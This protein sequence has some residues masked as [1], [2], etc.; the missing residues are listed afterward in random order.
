[1]TGDLFP[2]IDARMEAFHRQM[3]REA[4]IARH[5]DRFRDRLPWRWLPGPI[6]RR[7]LV[8][9]MPTEVTADA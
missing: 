7:V 3:E 8:W 4:R 2:E 9:L 6:R 5:Y 1:M